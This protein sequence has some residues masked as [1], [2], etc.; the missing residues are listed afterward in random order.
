[1]HAGA[2]TVEALGRGTSGLD[3]SC[4]QEIW[5]L[6]LHESEHL[7]LKAAG[8]T[9]PKQRLGWRAGLQVSARLVQHML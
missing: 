5:G 1:M 7:L 8:R 6:Y 9:A 3:L 4:Q 2:D